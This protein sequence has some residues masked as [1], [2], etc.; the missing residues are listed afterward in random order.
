MTLYIDQDQPTTLEEA[1]LLLTG[2]AKPL[3]KHF[4]CGDE[5]WVV[6]NKTGEKR[7]LTTGETQQEWDARVNAM[8][9]AWDKEEFERLNPGESW[10]G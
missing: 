5:Q 3:W 4:N 9:D 1:I 6:N 8:Y 10:E 2:E 7:N